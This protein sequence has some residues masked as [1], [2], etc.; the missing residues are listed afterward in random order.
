MEARHGRLIQV[1]LEALPPDV[2]CDLYEQAIRDY[3][4]EDALQTL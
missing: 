4:N 3:W 2:L 1:E